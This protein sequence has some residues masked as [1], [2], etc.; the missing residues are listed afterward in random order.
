MKLYQKLC[1][2][3]MP[4]E[5]LW[6]I[7]LSVQTVLLEY[8]TGFSFWTISSVA[9]IVGIVVLTQKPSG[10]VRLGVYFVLM[11]VFFQA[12]RYIS[13]LINPQG[14]LDALL[15]HWDELIFGQNLSLLLEP[16]SHPITT[17]ILSLAYL[18]FVVQ[19]YGRSIMYLFQ[20]G[21]VREYYF[22]GLMSLYAIGYMG[23]IFVPAV[24]PYMYIANE[25]SDPLNGY[26]FRDL[27]N[28]GYPSNTNLTDVFPSLHCAVSLFILLADYV[29][30]RTYFKISVIPCVLLWASTIYLRYHYGIDC[31]VG[32]LVAVI[33]FIVMRIYMQQ[34]EKSHA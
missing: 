33:C 4:H 17:E 30:H 26:V 6:L 5:I 22:V 8:Y 14:H 23:Y 32:F 31:L 27:L 13:P 21:N 16:Y 34:K 7:Y 3:F 2:C 19:L 1:S 9:V 28:W 10:F 15:Y 24:G 25:F 12:L 20:K 11:N 18:L 29:F